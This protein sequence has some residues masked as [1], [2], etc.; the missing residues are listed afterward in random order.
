MK[1]ARRKLKNPMPAAMP[2]KLQ[3]EKYREPVALT[4]A[5]QSTPALLKQMN[6]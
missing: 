3:R 2:C 5:R 1:N 4:S 6:L